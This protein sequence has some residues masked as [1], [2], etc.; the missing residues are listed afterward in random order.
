VQFQ[1]KVNQDNYP[2]Y[3]WSDS[4][5][6]VNAGDLLGGRFLEV[7]KGTAGLPTIR[8]S[9][10]HST[11]G[12]LRGKFVEQLRKERYAELK[13]ADLE[14]A[15]KAERPPKSDEELLAQVWG[16]LK[17]KADEHPTAYYTNL[18]PENVYFLTPVESPAVTERLERVMD[19]IEQALPNIL[20][21]TNRIATVLDHS[22]TLA[23]NLNLVAL[24]ARPAASNLA[25]LT[26]QLRGPGALGEWALGTNGQQHL[27]ATLANANTTLGHADTNLLLLAEN[28]AVS[29][30]NLAGITSNLNAQVQANTNILSSIS[31]AVIDADDLV[32]GLKKHWFL[33]SAFRDTTKKPPPDAPVVPV[34]SPKAR[35]QR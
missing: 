11:L 18:G 30:D 15:K 17:V 26:E 25:Y 3:I 1:I 8:E 23:S 13:T 12:V 16:E 10:N 19:N 21:L 34:L 31:Q 22:S 4:K 6:R 5:A 27:D 14:A 29:L 35:E 28:L 20:R 24:D 33:R 9:T 2:G 32:Q 7:T